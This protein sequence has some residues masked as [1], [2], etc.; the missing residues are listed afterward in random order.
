M[1]EYKAL[2]GR[3]GFMQI[4]KE[5]HNKNAHSAAAVTG[6]CQLQHTNTGPDNN[7]DVSNNQNWLTPSSECAFHAQRV[8]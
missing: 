5:D 1:F 4:W 7:Q 8:F 3:P 2:A 6:D